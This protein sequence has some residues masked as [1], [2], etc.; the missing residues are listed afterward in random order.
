MKQLQFLV[1]LALI[2]SCSE[3]PTRQITNASDYNAYLITSE[4]TSYQDAFDEKVFWSKRLSEDTTGVGNLGPLAGAYEKLFALTGDASFLYGAEKLHKKAI[5]N[6]AN[7][8]DAYVR[9]LAHNYITQHRFQEAKEILE[10]TYA[11]I[12]NKKATAFM[13]FDVYMELGDYEKADTFLGLIKN[14]SDY[15]YLIRLAKWSDHQGNLEAAIKYLEQARDIAESRNSRPLK[16][17]TYSNIADFYGHAGRLDEAYTHYLKTLE[18]EPDNTYAKKGIAWIL[19]SEEKNTVAANQILDS[20]MVNHK[21]PDY[22]LLKSE[23]ASFDENSEVAKANQ[24]L[25][26]QAVSEGDYGNM[27]NAYLIEI[28][29]ETNPTL[30]LQMAKQEVLNRPTPESYH[31]LALAQLINDQKQ[32]ALQTIKNH[33]DGKTFEPMAQYHSALVFKAN[34]IDEKVNLLKKELLKAGFELGPVLLEE[35]EAL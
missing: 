27:Y 13:L 8:K 7:N 11:G 20:I 21:V 31:L 29:A 30:A 19:Y 26:L 9:A 17:W 16:I 6:S 23:I 3:E 4:K 14:N 18:L 28:Y 25:F 12:S 32:T 34:G 1:L 24:K 33:V 10:E 15:S 22:Y 5:S 2:I 35:I